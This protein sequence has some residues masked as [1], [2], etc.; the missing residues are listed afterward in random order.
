MKHKTARDEKIVVTGAN[1]YVAK[2]LRRILGNAGMQV[3]CLARKNLTVHSGETKIISPD[4]DLDK[5]LP[6]LKN[7]TAMVHLA[8]SGIQSVDSDYYTSN[9]N[10]TKK[11]TELCIKAGIKRFVYNSGL[12]ASA[13]ST[14]GYFISKYQAEQI[15]RKSGLDYVIFRPS[16]IMG[17]GD[18]LA[19][20]IKKQKKNGRIIIPGSGKYRM[21]PIYILDA[22]SILLDAATLEKYSKKTLDLAGLEIVSFQDFV[23]KA[24]LGKYIVKTNLEDEYRLAVRGMG[25]FG[26]DDLCIMVG[27]YTGD[28]KPL[29]KLYKKRLANIDEMLNACSFA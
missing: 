26:L 17:R 28:V 16:Y 19:R 2:N 11:M 23:K 25:K 18:A 14:T 9:V 15:V 13:K 5:I 7:C 22:C 6:M 12:G 4:Y 24:G 1:G 20:N 29:K 10:L 27:D 8:G 3:I 21:Q